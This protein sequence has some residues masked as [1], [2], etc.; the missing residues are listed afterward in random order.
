MISWRLFCYFK[1]S[2]VVLVCMYDH[3]SIM[4]SAE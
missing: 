3:E 1:T 2:A 4:F